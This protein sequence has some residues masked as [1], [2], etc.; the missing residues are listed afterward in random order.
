MDEL[1]W[2]YDEASIIDE[3]KRKQINMKELRQQ[4]EA[5]ADKFVTGVWIKRYITEQ[6]KTMLEKYY[7]NL[8]DDDV[9]YSNYK[10]SFNFIAKFMGLP[11]KTIIIED[12]QFRHDNKDKEQMVVALRYSKGQ[13][14]VTIPEGV[15][16]IHVAPVDKKT[17]L[18]PSFRSKKK[19]RFMYPSYRVFFTV[20]KDIKPKKAGL[21]SAG[22]LFRYRPTKEIHEAYIDPTYNKFEDGS[23]YVET[24]TPIPVERYDKWL[25]KLFAKIEK[26]FSGSKEAEPEAV[27]EA[28]INVLDE[29]LG[30]MKTWKTSNEAHRHQIF[31]STTVKDEDYERLNNLLKT[32]NNVE[33]YDEYKKAFDAF[34]R[35]C[36]IVPRGTIL[37]RCDLTKGKEADRNNIYVEYSYNTKKM[38][39]PPE[40]DLYHHTKVEGIKE[41]KPFFRSKVFVKK[42]ES[43]RYFYDKPRIYLTVNK[44]MPK[45]LADYKH[46]DVLHK[47]KTKQKIK[48]AFVDPLVWAGVHGAMYIE[49]TKPLPVEEIVPKKLFSSKENTNEKS[50][51]KNEALI[52]FGC[53][54]NLWPELIKESD[55]SIDD[56]FFP[57]SEGFID[58][59]I[60]DTQKAKKDLM[61]STKDGTCSNN[62]AYNWG[63]VIK[64]YENNPAFKAMINNHRNRLAKLQPSA[65][66]SYN[67]KLFA[68]QGASLAK[69]ASCFNSSDPAANLQN[70]INNQMNIQNQ[71]MQQQVMM[72]QQQMDAVEA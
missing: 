56:E 5:V 41:L 28:A 60:D 52:E 51:P 34:C 67:K 23:I 20:A 25:E 31:R 57:I 29:F 37:C 7:N 38:D 13:A 6:Q 3:Y 72:Q 71:I 2:L 14:K 66:E 27:S 65:T 45:F 17:E 50:E 10:K 12:L 68:M 4:W 55:F 62:A 16:L 42:G 64:T 9:T 22:K 54:F 49:T 1:N 19:G 48:Q 70:D 44:N 11:S 33:E 30:K 8:I 43:R 53:E 21:S 61:S 59:I 32:M 46:S 24:D 40:L 26:R 36:H 47:Y 18:R 15:S 39:I 63:M 69:L 58:N 35:Y